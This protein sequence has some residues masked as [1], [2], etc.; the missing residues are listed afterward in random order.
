MDR[1]CNPLLPPRGDENVLSCAHK[2][3]RGGNPN[4]TCPAS[5]KCDPSLQLAR[6]LLVGRHYLPLSAMSSSPIRSRFLFLPLPRHPLLNIRRAV[7]HRDTFSLPPLHAP[8]RFQF[9]KPP[10]P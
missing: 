5:D 7:Q 6:P 1:R 2:A 8:N 4:S 9:P 10:I 3:L